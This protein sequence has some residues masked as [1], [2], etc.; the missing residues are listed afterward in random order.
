VITDGLTLEEAEAKLHS[1]KHSDETKWWYAYAHGH[2][3][4]MATEQVDLFVSII[5]QARELR[6]FIRRE[7]AVVA[8]RAR[9][10]A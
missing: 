6:E 4:S 3:C 2:G 9:L 5:E 1:L 7:K 10:A 8:A